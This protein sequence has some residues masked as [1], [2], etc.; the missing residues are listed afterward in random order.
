MS[1][2]FDGW[3]DFDVAM[4]GASAAALSLLGPDRLR[5]GRGVQ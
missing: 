4:A 5:S 1:A 2:T 3:T